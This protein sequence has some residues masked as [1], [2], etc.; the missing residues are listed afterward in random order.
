MTLLI[1][2]QLVSESNQREH[3][4]VRARRVRDQR[5]TVYLWL[6]H[7]LGPPPPLPLTITLTRVAPRPLDTDNLVSSFKACQDGAAD[8]LEGRY[9]HGQDRQAGLSWMYTQRTG[10]THEYA[11]EVRITPPGSLETSGV[12][13]EVRED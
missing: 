5:H 12:P 3:W 2:L 9:E 6:R 7:L 13:D 8:W 4:A 11:L 1:P 10:K